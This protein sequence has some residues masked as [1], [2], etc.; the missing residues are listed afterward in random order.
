MITK[1]ELLEEY[2][3]MKP[4]VMEPDPGLN[5]IVGENGSGKSSLLDAVMKD[6]PEIKLDRTGN[7]RYLHFDSEKNNPRV[8]G[9][10]PFNHTSAD[11]LHAFNVRNQSHGEALYPI[12]S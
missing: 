12:L 3:N 4:F 9:T 8:Q 11:I 1:I 6:I 10:L 5:F 2:R 7:E